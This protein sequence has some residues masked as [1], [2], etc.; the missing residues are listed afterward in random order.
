MDGFRRT[1]HLAT[2]HIPA[3]RPV[4]ADEIPP[5]IQLEREVEDEFRPTLLGALQKR[6]RRWW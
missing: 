4:L 6:R 2:D 1:V 5:F 3:P